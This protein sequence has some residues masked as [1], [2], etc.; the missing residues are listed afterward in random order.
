MTVR[1]QRQTYRRRLKFQGYRC[2]LCGLPLAH[3]IAV[4]V[5]EARINL[6][7]PTLDHVVPMAA[8]G[9]KG[10]ANTL[11]AHSRCNSRKNNRPA[12][13]CELLLLSM[14][15][16]IESAPVQRAPGHKRLHEARVFMWLNRLQ[17]EAQIERRPFTIGM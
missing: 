14:T 16:M 2:Y 3:E 13:A 12:R 5:R 8:G 7:Y 9:R 17:Y 10:R 1:C 6:T 11:W 15:N 4:F